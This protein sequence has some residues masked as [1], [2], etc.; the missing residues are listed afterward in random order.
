MVKKYSLDMNDVSD[1]N[2]SGL[3]NFALCDDP[4]RR[5]MAKGAVM[6][7]NAQLKNAKLP[8]L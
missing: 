2:A 4:H 3:N 8:I 1:M 6:F 5:Q 7:G